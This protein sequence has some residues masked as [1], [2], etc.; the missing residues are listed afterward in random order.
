GSDDNLNDPTY[1]IG[2]GGRGFYKIWGGNWAFW[3]GG[4]YKFNEKTSFNLQVSGDQDKNYGVAANVAYD[5]VPGFTVTAE[6]DWDHFGK[7]DDWVSGA[8]VV[9]FT[10]AD[11]KN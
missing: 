9:N 8:D 5:I 11:K 2:A 4:T 1:A 10:G 3:A 7:F 6:V